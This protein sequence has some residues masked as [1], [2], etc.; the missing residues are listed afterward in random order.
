MADDADMTDWKADELMMGGDGP[1]FGESGFILNEPAD[2]LSLDVDLEMSNRAMERHFDFDSAASSPSPLG[3]G[4]T[5]FGVSETRGVTFDT[6][7]GGSTK[8]NGRFGHHSKM[9]SVSKKC[10]RRCIAY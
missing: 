5:A 4:A 10:C 8:P 7:H 1:G 9:N 2:P 3:T 6:P